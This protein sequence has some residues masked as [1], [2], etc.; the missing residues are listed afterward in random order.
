MACGLQ[1]APAGI[2]EKPMLNQL[3]SG[4][5]VNFNGQLESVRREEMMPL[6]TQQDGAR[7]NAKGAFAARACESMRE[8]AA[9][10]E[11]CF[12]PSPGRTRQG[13][14]GEHPSS[15]A[16]LP[17]SNFGKLVWGGPRRTHKP[18]PEPETLEK[19]TL[20]WIHKG[21]NL[22]AYSLE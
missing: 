2:R 13:V 9:F 16:R 20:P 22:Q 15:G 17:Q 4:S 19:K 5:I 12:C 3:R 10:S 21:S 18:K 6:K 11:A 7:W 14:S 1:P 8:K